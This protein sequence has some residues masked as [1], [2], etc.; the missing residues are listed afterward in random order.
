MSLLT[1]N[2]INNTLE[3]LISGHKI[4]KDANDNLISN[5]YSIDITGNLEKKVV[6]PKEASDPD[7][8]PSIK[9]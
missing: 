7:W 8:G 3:T 9:Y 6:T 2:V 4:E 5:L 1:S